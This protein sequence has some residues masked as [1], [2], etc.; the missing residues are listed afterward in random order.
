MMLFNPRWV[1]LLNQ[2][3]PPGLIISDIKIK[4]MENIRSKYDIPHELF[5][6]GIMATPATTKMIQC[7]VYNKRKGEIFILT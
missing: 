1:K 3:L 5:A 7:Y 4:K 6:L 2:S